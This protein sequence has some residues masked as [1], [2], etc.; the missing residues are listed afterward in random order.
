MQHF[1]TVQAPAVQSVGTGQRV[2]T[3]NSVRRLRWRWAPSID[4]VEQDGGFG[5]HRNTVPRKSA[6]WGRAGPPVT[7]LAAAAAKCDDGGASERQVPRS[8]GVSRYRN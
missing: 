1:L 5:A 2:P 8:F 6:S 4:P 3:I 7:A